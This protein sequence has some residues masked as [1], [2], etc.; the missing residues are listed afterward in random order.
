[1]KN[2]NKH[3]NILVNVQMYLFLYSNFF[4]LLVI[5]Y[6]SYIP[7][8]ILGTVIDGHSE[9]LRQVLWTRL[10]KNVSKSL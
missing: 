10:C 7:W 6:Y 1:M 2:L 5:Y 4:G 9:I 3:G 8:G